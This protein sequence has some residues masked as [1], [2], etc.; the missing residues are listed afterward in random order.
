[1]RFFTIL[2]L[3]LFIGHSMSVQSTITTVSP[4]ALFEKMQQANRP[5]VV[6]FWVP[7]RSRA[8]EILR[9]YDSLQKAWN[10]KIDFYFVGITNKPELIQNAVAASGFSGTLYMADT[11]ASGPIA[12]RMKSFS[13]AFSMLAGKGASDWITVY[14]SPAEKRYLMKKGIKISERLM[15][16]L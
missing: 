15:E 12:S 10:G 5:A 8:T 11:V 4:A 7:N 14:F 9:E 13:S 16:K 2:F 3:A 6:Q 1:M